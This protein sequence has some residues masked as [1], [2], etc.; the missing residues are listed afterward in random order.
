MGSIENLVARNKLFR[1]FIAFP[2]EGPTNKLNAEAILY[3]AI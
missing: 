2:F 3:R 1:C